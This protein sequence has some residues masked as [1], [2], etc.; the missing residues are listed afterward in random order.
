MAEQTVSIGALDLEL[1]TVGAPPWRGESLARQLCQALPNALASRLDAALSRH[2]G[3]I[4]INALQVQLSDTEGI[5]AEYLAAQLSVLITRELSTSLAHR[6]GLIRVWADRPWYLASYVLHRMGAGDSPAWCFDEFAALRELTP[7]Q[8]LVTLC[9]AEPRMLTVLARGGHTR[10]LLHALGGEG[11][12]QLLAALLALPESQPRPLPAWPG[13]LPLRASLANPQRLA[14]DTLL[15]L[16]STCSAQR[17]ISGN[18]PAPLLPSAMALTALAALAEAGIP[19]PDHPAAPDSPGLAGIAQAQ[20]LP[21]AYRTALAIMLEDPAS[22]ELLSAQLELIRRACER[23]AGT[24]RH[25]DPEPPAPLELT[26]D[27]AGC[28]LLLP[29]ARNLGLHHLLSPGQLLCCLAATLGPEEQAD[30]LHDAM[31]RALCRTGREAPPPQWPPVPTYLAQQI[32]DRAL[33]LLCEPG[34][35]GWAGLLLAA[36]ATQLPGLR[37]SSAG[38]L[39]RQFLLVPGTLRLDARR[40]AVRLQGPDLAVVLAMAGLHGS[41]GPLPWLGDRP[42]YLE[43][44][45]LQP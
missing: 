13:E 39:R 1:H 14:E 32:D 45:G 21:A 34:A 41:Q 15:L 3:V 2:Q 29:A 35:G 5:D 23:P 37:H 43:M 20:L 9:A 6:T 4:R 19:L 18:S 12:R 40:A 10:L 11:C 36:F 33:G 25:P 16:L 26:S 22:R 30:A 38:Y 8:T 28:A 44:T 42:L 27:R 31:L 17:F 7:A 24:S